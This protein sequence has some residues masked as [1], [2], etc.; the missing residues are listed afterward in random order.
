[1]AMEHHVV[2][3]LLLRSRAA[4]IRKKYILFLAGDPHIVRKLAAPG[5]RLHKP[6]ATAKLN[7]S[8]DTY[9]MGL[10]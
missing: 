7:R 5:I 3:L 9:L 10:T 1:M 8:S 2:L 4:K 6:F